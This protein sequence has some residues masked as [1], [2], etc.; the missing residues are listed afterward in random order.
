[1]R[2]YLTLFFFVFW[3]ALVLGG[4]GAK[5][6]QAPPLALAVTQ[7]AGKYL[8]TP[9]VFGGRSPKGFDCSGLVWYVFRENGI[10]LPSNSGKQAKKGVRISFDELRPGDLVFFQKRGRINHVGIYVGDGKMIHAPGRG[11]KVRFAS[12]DSD[13]FRKTFAQARRVI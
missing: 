13:Y 12:L 10:E 7:T 1:M 6:P 9:Y 5:S 3:G 11:K 2:V 8:G 4:C